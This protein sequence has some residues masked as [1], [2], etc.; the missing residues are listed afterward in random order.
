MNFFENSSVL[1]VFWP[2]Q[3]LQANHGTVQKSAIFPKP[4]NQKRLEWSNTA[5][6]DKRSFTLN[7]KFCLSSNQDLILYEGDSNC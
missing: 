7:I 5:Y 6:V 1:G 2:R 3:R 4:G